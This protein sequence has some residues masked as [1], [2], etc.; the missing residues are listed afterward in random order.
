[1]KQLRKVH[2]LIHQKQLDGKFEFVPCGEGFFHGLFQYGEGVDSECLA[3]IE[4]LDGSMKTVFPH[5]IRFCEPYKDHE[6]YIER[7]SRK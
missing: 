1:M 4:L 7:T 6:E 3:V 2:L 5:M